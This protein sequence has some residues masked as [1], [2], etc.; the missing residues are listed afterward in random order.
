[1]L[2]MMSNMG[3]KSGV[4]QCKAAFTLNSSA[5]DFNLKIVAAFEGF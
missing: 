3:R 5:E 4:R 1:M 2:Y